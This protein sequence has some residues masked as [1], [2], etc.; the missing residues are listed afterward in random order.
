MKGKYLLL[1]LAF[2]AALGAVVAA[3]MTFMDWRLNPGG[4]F[5][6]ADGSD[7]SIVL[8]TALSWFGPVFAL[9]TALA[10]GV[11]YWRSR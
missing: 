9:S 10:L 11:C 8:E 6:G 7:W 1:S 4:I 2:G 3:I 5:H